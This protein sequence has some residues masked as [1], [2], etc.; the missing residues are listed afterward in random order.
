MDPVEDNLDLLLADW[1]VTPLEHDLTGAILARARDE[2]R[3]LGELLA[4]ARA[5]DAPRLDRDLTPAILARARAE[6][7]QLDRLLAQSADDVPARLPDLSVPVLRTIRRR[8]LVGRLVA[9]AGSVAAAAAAMLIWASVNKP[10]SNNSAGPPANVPVASILFTPS[11]QASLKQV[12]AASLADD[13]PVLIHMDTIKAMQQ[14]E[15]EATD[16]DASQGT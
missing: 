11:E 1:K 5:L 13:L 10:V 7:D 9:A 14:L 8:R 3:R 12:D 16:R 15:D 2:D 4:G 6:D